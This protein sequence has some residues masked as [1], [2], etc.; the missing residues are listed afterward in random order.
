MTDELKKEWDTVLGQPDLYIYGAAKTAEKLYEFIKQ[1]GYQEN[2][3]GFLVTDS[4]ENVEEMFDLPVKC[5]RLFDNKS[6]AILVPHMGIYR[7]QIC[8]LLES[9]AFHNVYQVGQL[10]AKTAQ[11]ERKYVTLGHENIG[12]EIYEQKS[13]KEKERDAGIREQVLSLLEEG[14]PDF[15]GVKPYQSLEMIG[16]R[17]IRPTE[18]RIREYELRQILKEQ[19]DVLDIGCNSGFLDISIAKEVR[20]VTGVEYDGSLV[21]IANLV[22]DYLG[23]SNCLFYNVDFNQWYRSAD[24]SYNAIFSFAIHH[25]LNLDSKEYVTIID[26]LLRRGGYVCFES[27]IYGADI[28]FDEC[29]K[30]FLE[31]GYSIVC[32]KKINDDGLQE[33]QFVL[34][35]KQG[36]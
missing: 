5:V 8:E 2:V 24:T 13:E 21:N 20:S 17:G 28:E 36:A 15:G 34:F 25:W 19:D 1:M 12:W 9:L 30:E 3:K 18:Y 35:R 7:K 29:Y 31:L 4:E 14:N 32:E 33:R 11:E 26:R 22:A 6:V 23:I 27:H 10:R 16:L